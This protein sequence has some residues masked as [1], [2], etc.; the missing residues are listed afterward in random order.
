MWQ[1]SC[2]WVVMLASLLLTLRTSRTIFSMSEICTWYLSITWCAA[3]IESLFSICWNA[4]I[5]CNSSALSL[6]LLSLRPAN[7]VSNTWWRWWVTFPDP[8]TTVCSC[9]ISPIMSLLV[10]S[11]VSMNSTGG[12]IMSPSRSS[13]WLEAVKQVWITENITVSRKNWWSNLG[14][15]QRY[16]IPYIGR[17]VISSKFCWLKSDLSMF[18]HIVWITF[19]I[20]DLG[21]LLYSLSFCWLM[22][23]CFCVPSLLGSVLDLEENSLK[24]PSSPDVPV[25]M[26][27]TFL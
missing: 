9:K 20:F 22:L 8:S 15:K 2:S 19:K 18:F 17:Q 25:F 13:G 24:C 10:L 26:F 23:S 7:C 27:L 3:R 12:E 6:S 21:K 4:A 16:Q 14:F 11:F 1:G 5:I